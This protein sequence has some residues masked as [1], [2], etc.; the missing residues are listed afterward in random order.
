[1]QVKVGLIGDLHFTDKP[2]GKFI[3]YFEVCKDVAEKISQMIISENLTH[4]FLA[5]DLVGVSNGDNTMRTNAARLWL[6]QMFAQW[7]QLLNGNLYCLRGNHDGGAHTCDFDI[8][9]GAMLI[10]HVDYVDC[11]A[12]RIHMID[13]GDDNRSLD[14]SDDSKVHV[15][16][17]HSHLTVE[18]KTNFIPF[19]GGTELS[20]MR[21]LK[22]CE[23]VACGHIHNPSLGYVST[24]IEG[25]DVHL[26]YLGCPTR[27]SSNDRWDK[28]QVLVLETDEVN[29]VTNAMQKVITFNLPPKDD[30]LRETIAEAKIEGIAPEEDVTN[31][32][33]LERILNELSNF[34]IGGMGSY[35]E[36][37]ERYAGLNKEAANL[38]MRYI[39]N[40]EKELCKV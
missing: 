28:T 12:F 37:L 8:L 40:A 16:F 32:E 6:I 24:S 26:I 36:Q 14:L 25:E 13:Y 10:K 23:I 31:V 4:L 15:A 5:G 17:M 20:T 29:G 21:N 2:V 33:D 35:K 19:Q 38:A 7:S 27:A 34:Q 9:M 3:D 11:G 30:L 39:E 1:M 22:G 18:N